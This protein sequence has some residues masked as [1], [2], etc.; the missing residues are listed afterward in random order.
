[1]RRIILT[2]AAVSALVIATSA[3]Q[4]QQ[5]Q[6][7][8]V[9]RSSTRLAVMTVSVKD[10]D[11]KVIE[12]LTPKDFTVTEDGKPQEIAFVEFQRLEGE[13]IAATT[14]VANTPA[15]P[16]AGAAAAPAQ[17]QPEVASVFQNGIAPPP[18]S[19]DIKY[20]N[21]RLIVLYFDL[22]ATPPPDQMRAY[23][24]A[25]KYIKDK[26]TTADLIAIMAYGGSAVRVKQDFT[27]NKEKLQQ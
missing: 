16:A 27:D 6:Q 21:K 25:L 17:P 14:L 23:D 9:F 1:M 24:A 13:P 26:M 11:G 3:Q 5:N 15:A 4:A 12:G 10:K 7:P 22:S 19:G 18:T 8:P 2:L 20:R